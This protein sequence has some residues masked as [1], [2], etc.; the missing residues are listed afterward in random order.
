MSKQHL[1]TNYAKKEA[2]TPSHFLYSCA[3]G[4]CFRNALNWK[5]K[6][7]E[8]FMNTEKVNRCEQIYMLLKFLLF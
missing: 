6:R 1:Y 3:N 8:Y 2:G 5:M 4:T 7:V